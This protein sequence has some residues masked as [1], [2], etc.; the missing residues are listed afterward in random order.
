MWININIIYCN[1][2]NEIYFDFF[3]SMWNIKFLD[4]DHQCKGPFNS[5][6]L[7]CLLY[8]CIYTSNGRVK[9]RREKKEWWYKEKRTKKKKSCKSF[10]I[11]PIYLFCIGKRWMLPIARD[12]LFPLKRFVNYL[13]FFVMWLYDCVRVC[14]CVGVRV[15]IFCNRWAPG[16]CFS[17]SQS[18][19]HSIAYILV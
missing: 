1:T 7:P 6:T 2:T 4:S 19:W 3:I 18:M 17:C 16:S 8:F 15:P 12:H 5:S 13:F 14:V 10:E 11:F 9:E